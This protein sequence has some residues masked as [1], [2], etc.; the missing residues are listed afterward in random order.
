MQSIIS[1]QLTMV[2]DTSR[3]KKE[4]VCP[5]KTN[6]S[7]GGSTQCT[8][9]SYPTLSKTHGQVETPYLSINKNLPDIQF[10][11]PNLSTHQIPASDSPLLLVPASPKPNTY[12]KNNASIVRTS[13]AYQS[14][15]ATAGWSDKILLYIEG[16][17]PSNLNSWRSTRLEPPPRP[18]TISRF[19]R[20]PRKA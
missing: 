15:L 7:G 13:L 11:N 12:P 17:Q 14:V 9:T 8:I 10:A 5:P 20:P 18:V 6:H 4:G 19:L 3:S 16:I 1:A 2:K